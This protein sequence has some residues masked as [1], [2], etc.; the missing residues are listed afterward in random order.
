MKPSLFA[1]RRR[2]EFAETDMAG[3]VH[4]ANFFRWLEEA[5]HALFRSFGATIMD[6]QPDGSV[7]SWPRVGAGCSFDSPAFYD[8]EVEI[9]LVE[10][11]VG[12]R[13]LTMHWEVW[14][15][16]NRLCTGELKTVCCAFRPGETMTSIDIP[17]SVRQALLALKS[18][19]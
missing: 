8:E 15:D 17:S 11:N 6:R 7:V 1:V 4:F 9:R 10:L 3:I 19:E 18:E 5:E 16:E 13:S 12:S 2:V 14:R